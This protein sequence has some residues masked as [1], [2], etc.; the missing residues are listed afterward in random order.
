MKSIYIPIDTDKDL[1]RKYTLTEDVLD[2]I[3]TLLTA[4]QQGYMV[5]VINILEAN[6]DPRV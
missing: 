5:E 3:E 1:Y 2:A 6:N 4:D